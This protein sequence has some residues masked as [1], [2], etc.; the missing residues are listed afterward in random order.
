M[1]SVRHYTIDI[2]K[3]ALIKIKTKMSNDSLLAEVAGKARA[4]AQVCCLGA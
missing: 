3:L 4:E 2:L 1:I